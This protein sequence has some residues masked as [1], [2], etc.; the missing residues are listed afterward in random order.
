MPTIAEEIRD[1]HPCRL[2]IVATGAAAGVQ[3]RLWQ[4]P[5]VSKFLVGCNF[6]YAS[7]ATTDF[8][9]FTPEQF[10]STETAIDLAM[11]AYRRAW[12]PDGPPAVGVGITASVTSDRPHKGD[13]RVHIAIFSD[14]GCLVLSEPLFKDQ[15]KEGQSYADFASIQR[16]H[17]GTLCNGLAL[18]AIAQ[19]FGLRSRVTLPWVKADDLAA[20]RLFAHPYFKADRTRLPKPPTESAFFPGAFNPPHF[21]HLGMA[22]AVRRLG[23]HV[24]FLT[25]VNPP[26]KAALTTAEVLQ[27]AKLLQGHD[28]LATKDDPLYID[29]ARAYPGASFILGT[30]AFVRLFDPKWG[31]NIADLCREFTNLGTKFHLFTRENQSLRSALRSALRPTPAWFDSMIIQHDGRWDVSSSELRATRRT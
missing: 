18:E 13:H 25:T 26:H 30:D 15:P 31:Y 11:E 10:C 8:L 28:F 22:D 5:G 17:D 19:T 14:K 24:V 3:N 2:Y 29:K 21:G 16:E 7:E 27:R 9:G 4:T 6:P 20:A 23:H 12:V 1:N